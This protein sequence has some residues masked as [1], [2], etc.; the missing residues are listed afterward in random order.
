MARAQEYRILDRVVRFIAPGDLVRAKLK[1]A[2]D[3]ARRR[4]KRIMDV[5]D[6]A[7]LLEEHPEVET[8]L[9]E[10]ERALASSLISAIDGV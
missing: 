8:E 4:S 1:A 3:P 2:S 7:T 6:I 9:G 5:G 10:A